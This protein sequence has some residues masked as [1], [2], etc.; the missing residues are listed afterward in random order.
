MNCLC[1]LD[2]FASK[3]W[4][5]YAGRPTGFLRPAA[6]AALNARITLEGKAQGLLQGELRGAV[7][8][9]GTITQILSPMMWGNMY[10]WGVKIGK[11]GSFF[12]MVA[13]G[14]VLQ[15]LAVP[16][17]LSS[18]SSGESSAG[19]E[20][21]AVGATPPPAGSTSVAAGSTDD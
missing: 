21:Q 14:A 11:P 16:L 20:S 17:L 1:F 7:N 5:H 13:T 12:F 3:S 9:L 8:N 4:H 19:A 6:I 2:G 10:S 15:L 18:G